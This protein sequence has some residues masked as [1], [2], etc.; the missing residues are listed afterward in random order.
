MAAYV[1]ITDKKEQD[2]LIFLTEAVRM[3]LVFCTQRYR[4]RMLLSGSI[5]SD[6]EK[7]MKLAQQQ[8]DLEFTVCPRLQRHGNA[9]GTQLQEVTVVAG[10][11]GRVS[12]VQ[13][14]KS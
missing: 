12:T 10:C 5:E 7:K 3:W 9:K 8:M 6:P 1:E 2:L 14:C 11:D 13:E 4:I